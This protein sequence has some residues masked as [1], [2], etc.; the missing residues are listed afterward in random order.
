MDVAAVAGPNQQIDVR[1]EEVTVHRHAA[2]VGEHKVRALPELLDEAEDV[3]PA[4]AVQPGGVV[5][6]L[7]ENLIHLERGEDRLDQDRRAD[8]TAGDAELVLREGER[9]V[10]ETRLV[11][12]LELGQVEIRSRALRDERR[13]VVEEE[14][15]KIEERGGNRAPVDR[16]VFLVEMPA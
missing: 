8:R 4:P 13:R 9:V 12:A 2:A 15:T 10:P 1:L 11:V 14:E 7:I 5:L 16:H 3:V 6:Q